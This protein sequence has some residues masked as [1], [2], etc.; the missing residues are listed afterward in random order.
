[1][2]EAPKEFE[3]D[4]QIVKKHK[5][6]LKPKTAWGVMEVIEAARYVKTPPIKAIATKRGLNYNT[7][8]QAY[9]EWT[10]GLVDLGEAEKIMPQQR[11]IDARIEMGRSLAFCDRADAFMNDLLETTMG[12][13]H[14]KAAE[15]R[16]VAFFELGVPDMIDAQLK[17]G[18]LRRMKEEG[19]MAI[20]EREKQRVQDEQRS[21]ADTAK[22]V[23]GEVVKT[24]V[25]EVER[26]NAAFTDPVEPAK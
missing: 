20:L 16:P 10:K 22:P 4:V 3:P 1:M 11:E 23:N 13:V 14:A 15:G 6:R 24:T 7:L 2:S 26:F 25:S 17:I 5:R 19:F 12:V 18:R 21:R 9:H 8:K